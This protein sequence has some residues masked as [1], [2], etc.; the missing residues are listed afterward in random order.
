MKTE[1]MEKLILLL[2]VVLSSVLSIAQ[3][4][5]SLLLKCKE[6]SSLQS[7]EGLA[8]EVFQD[9]LCWEGLTQSDGSVRFN[10]LKPGSVI[11]NFMFRD[12]FEEQEV[13][14]Q[15]KQLFQY[16][17][18]LDSSKLKLKHL[19]AEEYEE[20]IKGR[21]NKNQPVNTELLPTQTVSG[22]YSSIQQIQEVRV[23]A[24]KAPFINRDCGAQAQMITRDEISRMPVRSA[25]GIATT[26]GGV[27]GNETNDALN[28]R[29]AR[30]DANYYYIDGVK[31]R[32]SSQVPKSYMGEVTIYT[33]SIPAN[34]GDVT[35]GVISIESKPIPMGRVSKH[36]NQT[37]PPNSNN[38]FMADIV[39]VELFN[40][41]NFLPIYENDFLSPL[42]HPNATFGLDV[43]QAAWEYL[44][45]TVESGRTIQRDAVKLE[46][47]INAF[48]HKKVVVPDDE[49]FN[50]NIT[51]SECSW[52]S[53]HELV[54]VHLKAKDFPENNIRKPHNFVFLID[55]SG[56]M[57]SRNRL[58]LIVDGLRNFVK[59]LLPEDRISIVS[60]SGY[61]GVVLPSTSCE[62]KEK[63][64]RALSS[65]ESGGSTNGIGGIKEAYRQAEANFDTIYNNRIILA[66]DGDF[67]VGINSP[68]DLENYI[69]KKRGK[70]IYLTALG[71]GM[72]NYKNSTLETLAK[73]GDGNHFYV[74]SLK[75]INQVLNNE[76]NLINIARD[77]KLNVEF[78]P[79]LVSNYRLIGYENR[80]LK[81]K[82]FDDDTKDGGELGYGHYVSA[83]F[84]VERGQAGSL[85]NHFVKQKSK[86]GKSDLAYV[87]LRYK[88]LEDSASVQRDYSILESEPKEDN[89]LLS[90]VIALGLELRDS[91]F[92]GDLTKVSLLKQARSFKATTK[93][94]IE[95]KN[96]IFKLFGDD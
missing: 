69:A 2:T 45:Y 78:N 15:E 51:R 91:A 40:Y 52:N 65:L 36:T 37:I 47:M 39:E 31:V 34:Y 93:K 55:V 14:I 60:Y 24:Y 41:D 33:G 75:D 79:R 29:G 62:N 4:S 72:G 28:I 95:L 22:S 5:G 53:E 1:I 86:F 74:R 50:V 16:T 94:E 3:P 59:S 26:V 17:V 80:L 64:L 90:L 13:F 46:E 77:V 21:T 66:T 30:E 42:M 89:A 81:P 58:P 70:G 71:V 44:K 67:N 73:R 43:D 6:K 9:S 92:K 18:L 10:E 54:S 63:I 7:I 38:Q 68:G 57:N 87:K 56:S 61:S 19:K 25:N 8:V 96:L 23:V 35:G 85:E 32:G 12:H 27:N 20:S 84:E 82:D 11:V 88:P 48:Q 76:G 83:V 49:L